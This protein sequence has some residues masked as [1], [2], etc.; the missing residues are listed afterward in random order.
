[1][2]GT[3]LTT[4]PSKSG[5]TDD[6]RSELAKETESQVSEHVTRPVNLLSSL[7]SRI[8]FNGGSLLFVYR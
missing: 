8:H 2:L 3:F 5:V 4:V 1:M 7:E 6:I